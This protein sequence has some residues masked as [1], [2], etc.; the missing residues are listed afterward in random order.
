MHTSLKVLLK[1]FSQF[2]IWTLTGTFILQVL[3]AEISRMA[4]GLGVNDRLSVLDL[5]QVD[6]ASRPTA[7]GMSSTLFS[8]CFTGSETTSIIL[9]AGPKD[10]G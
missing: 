8:A 2:E 3:E 9:R 7:A 1:R 6:P 5:S 4:H 10:R